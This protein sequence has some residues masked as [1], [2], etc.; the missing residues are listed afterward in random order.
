MTSQTG[1]AGAPGPPPSS[2]DERRRFRAIQERLAP[3]VARTSADPHAPRTVVIVPSLS[4]DP[5]H[6]ARIKGVGYYEE[7]LLCLLGLLRGHGTRV[8]FLTSQPVAPAIVDYY[9]DLLTGVPIDQARARLTLLSCGDASSTPLSRKVLDRP[10]LLARIRDAI[11]EPPAAYMLCFNS[12]PLERSLAV[13]LGIPLYGC[14]PDLSRAGAKSGGREVFRAAGVAMP[15]GFENLRDERDLARALAELKRVRPSLR[16]AVAKLDDGFSGIGNAVFPYD[17]A[18]ESLHLVRWVADELPR[19]LRFEDRD[20]TW[21]R[22]AGKLARSGGVVEA[23]VEGAEGADI[24]SPSVQCHIDPLGGVGIVSTHE[25]VLGGPSGQIFL[26][27]S[28]PADEAYHREIQGAATRV[29]AVL[30]DRGIVGRFGID[31]ISARRGDGWE[32]AAVEINLRKGGTTHPYL[33]LQFLTGGGYDPE[34]GLHRTAHSQARYYV[35]TDNL[36][37]PVYRGLTPENL[38]D[39]AET[40]G[41]SFDT[42]TQQGVVF[43]L[44]GA[45]P[46]HGKL[47]AVCIGDSRASA[48]QLYHRTITTLDSAAQQEPP[49]SG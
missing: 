22:Y 31:F 27:C 33:T 40:H 13:R 10:P 15:D 21:E 32:H 17:G 39:I 5:E 44:M 8:V 38:M 1:G 12:T 23:F 24:R 30:R 49:R 46:E 48:E 16:R 28:F 41:L 7:R 42:V 45:L 37:S 29:A 47:G 4:L 43:H 26:G 34:S 20:E 14:D 3:L 36:H 18:P 2:E 25:Q 9:L 11:P 6:L 19:R 35:A